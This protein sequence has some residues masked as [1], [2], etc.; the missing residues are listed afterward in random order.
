MWYV[1]LFCCYAHVGVHI[2]ILYNFFL[3][4]NGFYLYNLKSSFPF[5][6]EKNNTFDKK[7]HQTLCCWTLLQKISLLGNTNIENEKYYV[8]AKLNKLRKR[9]LHTYSHYKIPSTSKKMFLLILR[10]E[11][12]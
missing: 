7:N 8:L 10:R 2:L 12:T 1:L 3:S 5:A 9:Y 4:S 11:K 6:L